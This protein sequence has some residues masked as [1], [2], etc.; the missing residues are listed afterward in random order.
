MPQCDGKLKGLGLCVKHYTRKRRYG[1]PEIVN[2]PNR[3][4]SCTR[5]YPDIISRFE[6]SYEII[7]ETGCWIWKKNRIPSGYGV[8]T[9][10]NKRYAA[11]RFSYE[12]FK[13]KIEPGYFV[14]HKCDVPSCINPD[15]LFLG[16]AIE[17]FNDM[18][19]KKR[20]AIGIRNR[21]VKLTE[22]DVIDIRNKDYSYGD[23]KLMCEKYNVSHSTICRAR[24]GK[25]WKHL[26]VNNA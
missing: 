23:L 10:D 5:K 1:D 13:G 7:M 17:N 25:G 8:L 3:G 2:P 15:H 26:K 20:H 16:T 22:Q 4:S 12:L 14:C 6:D 18:R 21:A 19:A 11:H 24:S 9:W